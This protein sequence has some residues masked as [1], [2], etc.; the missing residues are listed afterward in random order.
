MRRSVT[1]TAA[2]FVL[3]LC[4]VPA[5]VAMVLTPEPYWSRALWLYIAGMAGAGAAVGWLPQLRRPATAVA[6]VFAAQVAAHGTVTIRGLFNAQGAW[7]TG[8][9]PHEMASRVALAAVVA[10]VGTVAACTAV[11]LLCREPQRGWGPGTR[12]RHGWWPS[13]W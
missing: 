4:S 9:A 10:L 8:L 11:A 5:T 6:M 12:A 3:V 7:L 1:T 2:G 13:V